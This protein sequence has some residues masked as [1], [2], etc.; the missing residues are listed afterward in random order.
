MRSHSISFSRALWPVVRDPCADVVSVV[1]AGALSAAR[2]SEDPLSVSFFGGFSPATERP[3]AAG[4]HS[5]AQWVSHGVAS[6]ARNEQNRT[7]IHI[8]SAKA[9]CAVERAR[10][11]KEGCAM[12]H[13]PFRAVATPPGKAKVDGKCRFGASEG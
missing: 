11:G 8:E 4:R 10:L 3:P 2:R 6:I 9:Q 13:E 12:S 5:V 1:D 7:Y